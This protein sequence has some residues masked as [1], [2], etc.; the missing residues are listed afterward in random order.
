MV[1][2]PLTKLKARTSINPVDDA[3]PIVL[4]DDQIDTLLRVEYEE[5]KQEA[6]P[7][8]LLDK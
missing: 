5:D 8:R 3:P 6:I 4:F 1:G 7:M 2:C